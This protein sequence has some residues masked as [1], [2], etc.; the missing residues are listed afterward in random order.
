M[1]YFHDWIKVNH[2]FRN[3]NAYIRDAFALSEQ[4]RGS[5][6]TLS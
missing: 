4:L 1:R 5:N 3:E 2:L 6:K